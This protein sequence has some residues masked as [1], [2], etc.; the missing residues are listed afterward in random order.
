MVRPERGGHKEV[1]GKLPYYLLNSLGVAHRFRISC[2]LLFLLLLI[3]RRVPSGVR[4]RN[5][6]LYLSDLGYES[7]RED[8]WRASLAA[9]S[10]W[11]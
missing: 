1:C 9:G 10:G 6:V 5:N 3:L 7:T 8:G 2:F 11:E 4:V